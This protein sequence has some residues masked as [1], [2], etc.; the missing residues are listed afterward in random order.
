MGIEFEFFER[1]LADGTW[2]QLGLREGGKHMAIRTSSD[3]GLSRRTTIID[4]TRPNERPFH[5]D[6]YDSEEPIDEGDR[7]TLALQDPVFGSG[8]SVPFG[9][10]GE[11]V[12]LF[13][14]WVDRSDA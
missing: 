6:E 8:P 11:A 13:W 1:T 14:G 7:R 9:T 5:F 3:S 10:N 2:Q 12:G 4:A